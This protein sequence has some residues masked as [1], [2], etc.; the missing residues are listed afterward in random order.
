MSLSHRF[1]DAGSDVVV[2]SSPRRLAL[3][4]QVA[5]ETGLSQIVATVE[6]KVDIMLIEGYKSAD[7]PKVVVLGG[8]EDWEK[9]CYMDKI[10]ATILS[11]SSSL[12][13]PCFADEDVSH[14]I[15]LL[16]ERIENSSYP[17]DGSVSEAAKLTL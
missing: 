3:I 15:D 10:L 9:F 13:V 17:L 8:E 4:E 12:G 14:I 11:Q 2:L 6:N 5:A 7:V 1:T 16:V